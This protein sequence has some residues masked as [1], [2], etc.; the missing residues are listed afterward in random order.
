M[1]CNLRSSYQEGSVRIPINRFNPATFRACPK[2][3]PGFPTSYIV[4]TIFCVHRV[5]MRGDFSFY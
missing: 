2:P 4:V 1:Y 3:G 5:K